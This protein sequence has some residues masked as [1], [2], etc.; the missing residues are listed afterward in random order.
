M[1][2]DPKIYTLFS[3]L[4]LIYHN[5]KFKIPCTLY[6]S[7]ITTGIFIFTLNETLRPLLISL[8]STLPCIFGTNQTRIIYECCILL[9]TIM[10]VGF[11]PFAE[12]IM[13]LF[14][15]SNIFFQIIIFIIP[16]Y[17]S[18]QT[19]QLLAHDFLDTSFIIIGLLVS[20]YSGICLIFN[21]NLRSF[22]TYIIVYFYGLQI[23]LLGQYKTPSFFVLWCVVLVLA[24]AALAIY[25]P[26]RAIKYKVKFIRHYTN[27][28]KH[29]SINALALSVNAILILICHICVCRPLPHQLHVA[30]F[31]MPSC[32]MAKIIYVFVQNASPQHFKSHNQPKIIQRIFSVILVM[33][34]I[35]ATLYIHQHMLWTLFK[36]PSIVFIVTNTLVFTVTLS[37]AFLAMNIHQPKW[38]TSRAYFSTILSIIKIIKITF[39]IIQAAISDF[40]STLHKNIIELSLSNVPKKLSNILYNNHVYFYI[41]FLLQVIVVLTIEC[42]ILS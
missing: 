11:I 2:L 21:N 12:W 41:F 7:L 31:V 30:L 6:L 3:I 1:I 10:L 15:I 39:L 29:S 27:L 36:L 20:G 34:T 9:A 18:L 33:T 17:L 13:Y 40:T 16:M 14:A 42:V 28:D 22:F 32:L 25:T 4:A 37:F 35:I 19:M 5:R 23:F 24:F 38:L 8:I 26:N